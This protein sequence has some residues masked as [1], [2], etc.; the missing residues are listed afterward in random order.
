MCN[1]VAT[2]ESLFIPIDIMLQSFREERKPLS[3]QSYVSEKSPTGGLPDVQGGGP[4][5]SNLEV[6]EPWR[7]K[8]NMEHSF[9]LWKYFP[10]RL[11][12]RTFP[13]K[14]GMMITCYYQVFWYFTMITA[15]I[16]ANE[17]IRAWT[18]ITLFKG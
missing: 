16:T 18:Q 1:G 6:M 13:S 2:T 17:Y 5:T 10:G 7:C 15:W 14:N 8:G 9:H 12:G 3:D 11:G 4:I